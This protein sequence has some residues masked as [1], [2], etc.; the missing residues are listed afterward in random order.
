[1][2]VS[3]CMFSSTESSISM[4]S[5]IYA[6][7]FITKSVSFNLSLIKDKRNLVF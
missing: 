5:N 6:F 4:P 3:K 2:F 7:E 1:M